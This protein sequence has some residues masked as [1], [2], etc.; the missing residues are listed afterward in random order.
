MLKLIA[1]GK[2][3]QEIRGRAVYRGQDGQDPHHPHPVQAGGGRPNPGGDLRPP[4]QAGGLTS[5]IGVMGIAGVSMSRS[6]FRGGG[7]PLRFV[8]M[9]RG[10]VVHPFL[11]KGTPSALLYAGAISGCGDILDGSFIRTPREGSTSS[12]G[13]CHARTDVEERSVGGVSQG[14]GVSVDGVGDV[15]IVTAVEVE[16]MRSSAAFGTNPPLTCWREASGP[17]PRRPA[18]RCG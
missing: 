18:R 15:L 9:Q 10:A 12:T 17:R 16:G 11:E 14:A 1:E 6:S 8:A 13:V 7:V 2:S 5:G 3:N 4:P